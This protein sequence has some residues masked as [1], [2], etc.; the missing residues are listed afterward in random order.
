MDSYSN[1]TST[2]FTTFTTALFVFATLNHLTSYFYHPN[3]IGTVSVSQGG[4]VEYSEF[5]PYSADQVKFEFDL[6]VDLRSEYNWNVNQL[7]VFVVASYSTSRNSKNEVV[8]YDRILRD[9]ADYK[10]SL[11]SIKNKYVLRDEF[12]NTL[13]GRTVEL[14]IRYQVMPIFGLLRIKELPST[15]T[16]VVPKE[17]NRSTD[18]G[19][20]RS[21][22]R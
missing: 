2:L 5:K 16:L 21:K 10:F 22:S 4:V 17:Y 11:N 3:P 9:V 12:K 1:R 18:E 8:I 13:A 14:K 19:S 6:K 7:Y 15:G 20:K